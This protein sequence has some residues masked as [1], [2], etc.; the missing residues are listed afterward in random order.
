MIYEV[1]K[2]KKFRQIASPTSLLR[3]FSRTEANASH[4]TIPCTVSQLLLGINERDGGKEGGLSE[5]SKEAALC[6]FA[7]PFDLAGSRGGGG[8]C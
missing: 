3:D 4:F 6:R 8:Q 1:K 5:M 2:K 7:E